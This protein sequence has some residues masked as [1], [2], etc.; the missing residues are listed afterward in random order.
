MYAV[1]CMVCLVHG[2]WCVYYGVW[3]VY[4]A[5]WCVYYG[6]MLYGVFTMVHGVFTM[7]HGCYDASYLLCF[8]DYARTDTSLV[9]NHGAEEPTK[10][11][12]KHFKDRDSRAR[13]SRTLS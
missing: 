5:A 7:L 12:I 9:C 3:C 6:A 13:V 1:W 4:Y 11:R 10:K 8:S 2:A